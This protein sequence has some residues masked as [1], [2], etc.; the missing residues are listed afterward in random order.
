MRRKKPRMGD[1]LL[2]YNKNK[3]KYKA[4]NKKFLAL[5]AT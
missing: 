4:V 5:S 3:L 2:F 1:I